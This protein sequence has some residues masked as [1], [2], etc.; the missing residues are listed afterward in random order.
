MR[1]YPAVLHKWLNADEEFKANNPHAND[2]LAHLSEASPVNKDK[3]VLDC[4]DRDYC[5]W[6]Y[7]YVRLFQHQLENQSPAKGKDSFVSNYDWGFWDS[8]K[9]I[10]LESHSK[11]SVNFLQMLE[12]EYLEVN[13][14]GPYD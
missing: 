10:E 12:V 14:F 5:A 6:T 2:I 9:E 13:D 11:L 3:M 7:A 4:V 1:M 8:K